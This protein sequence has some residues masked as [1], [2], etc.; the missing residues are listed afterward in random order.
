MIH[1]RH[2]LYSYFISVHVMPRFRSLLPGQT[3]EPKEEEKGKIS[4]LYLKPST[5]IHSAKL[6]IQ[7]VLVYMIYLVFFGQKGVIRF[8]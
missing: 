5:S 7:Q 4:F 6:F 1:Q 2:N 3:T 8:F